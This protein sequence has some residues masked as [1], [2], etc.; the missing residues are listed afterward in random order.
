MP[1]SGAAYARAMHGEDPPDDDEPPLA[2]IRTGGLS[3]GFALARL[4]VNAGLRVTGHAVG[5]LF[6]GK[7]RKDERRRDL[8]VR[9]AM[10]L[11]RELGELKG[12]MMKVG[13]MLS[14]YGEALLPP[15][16][17]AVLKTLQSRAPILQ[18]EAIEARL[19]EELGDR[20]D[21]LDVETT[22]LAA[23]SLGQVHGAVVRETGARIV[24]KVQY[25]GVDTAVDTDL[26]TLKQLL[27]VAGLAPTGLSGSELFAEV[28]TMLRREVD[29]ALERSTTERFRTALAGAPRLKVPRTWPRYCTSRVLATDRVQ[30]LRFDDDAVLALPQERRDALGA[31]V[32]EMLLTEVFVL[33]EVQ[34]DP[35]FGNYLVQLADEGD[36]IT[37][38]DFGAVRPIDD[39]IMPTYVA[40]IAGALHQSPAL[41]ERVGRDMGF[42]RSGDG[43][44]LRARFTDMCLMV[45]EP[46]ADPGRPGGPP[47][48]MDADGRYDWGATDLPTRLAAAGKD[49]V[50]AFK[51]RTPPA[52]TFFLDRKLG[53]VYMILAVLGARIDG[54]A[55][56]RRFM[57]AYGEGRQASA[58]PCS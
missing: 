24:L 44:S 22:P 35:H 39:A 15:E 1:G 42:L 8:L 27:R 20:L 47:A 10:E 23:A 46:F 54:R 45:V 25:P 29:Y 38:L 52:W 2:A 36:S 14:T 40:F 17:N 9:Q 28:R 12:S 21:E 6:A 34:T 31:L 56:L 41:M 26:S 16:A 33:R 13:Q 11:T 18:W 53:G 49:G 4:G 43:E 58:A 37:L 55:I 50:L 30:G 57:D 51:L 32:F 3:R 48:H 5:G 19:R 7:D